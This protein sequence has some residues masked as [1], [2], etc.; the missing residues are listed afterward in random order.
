VLRH[1][2]FRRTAGDATAAG[3]DL[4]TSWPFSIDSEATSGRVERMTGRLALI[5]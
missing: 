4:P 3:R 5:H 1:G 2:W